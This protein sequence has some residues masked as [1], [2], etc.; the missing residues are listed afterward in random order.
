[1]RIVLVLFFFAF[2]VCFPVPAHAGNIYGS[3]WIDGRPAQGAQIQI[4]CT[5]PHPA[6]TDSNGSYS[7]FVPENGRCVFHVDFGGHSGETAIASYGNPIKYDFDL[8]RQGDGNYVLR[9]R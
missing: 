9:S 4:R 3:L 7:V 2:L 6:Q 8:I 1:M 5:A